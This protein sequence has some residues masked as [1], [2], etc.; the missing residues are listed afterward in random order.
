MCAVLVCG[1]LYLLLSTLRPTEAVLLGHQKRVDLSNLQAGEWLR[2]DW[3]GAEVFVLRR[4]PAQ[5][6]WLRQN[7]PPEA[8]EDDLP[9]SG[10]APRLRSRVPEIFVALAWEYRGQGGSRVLLYERQHHAQLCDEFIYTPE[11]SPVSEALMAPGA[12]R[13]ISILGESLSGRPYQPFRYAPAGRSFS[14][15]VPPLQVPHYMLENNMLTLG[16]RG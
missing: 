2:L 11:L 14:P 3:E 1:V 6:E 7:E 4:T 5:I 8:L 16:E 9:S 10:F 12:F 15:R 13:C